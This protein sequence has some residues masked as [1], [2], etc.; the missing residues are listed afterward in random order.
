M[1]YIKWSPWPEES[2]GYPQTSW[3][4]V[5]DIG[6][7]PQT[8]GKALLLNIYEHKEV[9]LLHNW[10]LHAYSIVFMELESTLYDKEAQHNHRAISNPQ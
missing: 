10:S 2:H 3:P 9:R 1:G 5:R 7:F 8:N 6:C 4:I